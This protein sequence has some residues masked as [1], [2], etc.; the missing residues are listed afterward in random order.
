MRKIGVL[1][2]T[3]LPG[4]I[5]RWAITP[6]IGASDVGVGQFEVGQP[7]GG[8]RVFQVVLDLV[9]VVGADQ[10]L[11]GQL[12]RARV[13]GSRACASATRSARPAVRRAP[14]PAARAPGRRARAGLPRPARSARRRKSWRSPAIR[15]ALPAAPCRCSW[16]RSGRWVAAATSTGT[17]S[18]P[19]SPSLAWASPSAPRLQP[20]IARVAQTSAE[21]SSR[22]NARRG[23]GAGDGADGRHVGDL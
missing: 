17:A 18:G 6:E 16:R 11:L 19:L 23:R 7:V 10:L 9:D 12:A 5:E 3:K 2:C 13:V 4:L 20:T 22:G 14:N 15:R 21:H 8:A 1:I